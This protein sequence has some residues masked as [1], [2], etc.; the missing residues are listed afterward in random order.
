MKHI[1]I[2]LLILSATIISFACSKNEESGQP[3]TY[4]ER[5]VGKWEE[6]GETNFWMFDQNGTGW[7][8]IGEADSQHDIFRW[9]ISGKTLTTAFLK[10]DGA[11]IDQYDRYEILEL[12]DKYLKVESDEGVRL[13]ERID[14]ASGDNPGTEI[15]NAKLLVG[16]WDCTTETSLDLITNHLYS[17]SDFAG[18]LT[19]RFNADGTGQLWRTYQDQEDGGHYDHTDNYTEKFQYSVNGSKIKITL[20]PNMEYDDDWLECSEDNR[21]ITIYDGWNIKELTTTKL[22]LHLH[23]RDISH[24]IIDYDEYD[25]N[26]IFKRIE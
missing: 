24:D 26:R 4:S 11:K 19:I 20:Y 8:G 1:A 9:N 15:G 21:N 3:T 10:T 25:M 23:V 18:H 6:I 16:K 12:S 14:S 7:T 2:A 22:H 13:F 5:I 17:N